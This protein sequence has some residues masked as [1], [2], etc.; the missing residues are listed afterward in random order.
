MF[1]WFHIYFVHGIVNNKIGLLYGGLRDAIFHETR[2][3]EFLQDFSWPAQTGGS[4]PK[5]ILE[6][7]G[8]K[9]TSPLKAA[10]SELMNF[11][12]VLRLFLLRFVY[13]RIDAA[14]MLMSRSFFLLVEV[15]E[16]LQKVARGGC[17]TA[18]K[19]RAAIEAHLRCHLQAYAGS[20]WVP[21]CHMALHLPE[22][23]SRFGTLVSCF[24]HERKH[25]VIKRF[26]SQKADTQRGFE[27]SLLRDVLAVQLKAMDQ[28]V[29]SP[30]A[31][32]LKKT[33][34]P[35]KLKNLIHEITGAIN[36]T[37]YHAPCAVHGGGFECSR[38]DVVVF[39][40]LGSE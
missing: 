20:A 5:Q 25:K 24:V 21:K 32:L 29:P 37:V 17:V 35:R 9:K 22:Y 19:L 2:I 4:S 7:S 31:G 12:P 26:A 34:A 36:E 40:L 28:Q 18:S 33:P 16:L 11:L 10:A 39:R 27:E 3:N 23:M 15:T 14:T 8:D 30:E 13:G 6:A 38:G 1:D